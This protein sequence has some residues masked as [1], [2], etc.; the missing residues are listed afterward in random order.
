MSVCLYLRT[1][2]RTYVCTYVCMYVDMYVRTLAPACVCAYVCK[3]DVRCKQGPVR[4]KG[5]SCALCASQSM[6]ACM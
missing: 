1:Y 2:V 4:A 6:D 5:S 3:T